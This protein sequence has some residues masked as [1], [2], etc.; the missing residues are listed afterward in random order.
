VGL[1]N[2]LPHL[3]AISYVER[4][5]KNRGAEDCREISNIG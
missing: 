2:G 1:P 3:F 5:R 4:Q